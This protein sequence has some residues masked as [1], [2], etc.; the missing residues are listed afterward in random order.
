MISIFQGWTKGQVFVNGF[1]LGR[2]WDIGPQESL[3]VP[4][5]LLQQGDNQVK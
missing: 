3:Y 5:P 2:Y 4:G 1:N